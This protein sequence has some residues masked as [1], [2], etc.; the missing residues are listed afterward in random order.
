MIILVIVLGIVLAVS[1]YI[2]VR[3][4]RGF[5]SLMRAIEEDAFAQGEVD[6]HPDSIQESFLQ[7][8]L[9]CI[10]KHDT[11]MMKIVDIS[12][13]EEKNMIGLT[14]L[15]PEAIPGDGD[16]IIIPN[17]NVYHLK[18]GRWLWRQE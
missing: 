13:Y 9:M 3:L 17:C 11:Q 5:S 18:D 10:I 16:V 15:V 8:T 12:Q 4:F 6:L 7:T 2:N 14:F 1:I